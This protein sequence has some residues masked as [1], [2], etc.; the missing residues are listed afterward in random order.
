MRAVCDRHGA[1]LIL[2]EVMCGMGRS[3][4]LHAWEQEGVVP[5]IQMIAK[6]L[7]GGYQPIGG[8]LFGDKI[9]R[10]M[11]AG[12]GV[13]QHG[14]TYSAHPVACAAA[15]AVQQVIAEEGLLAN[16]VAR[17]AQLEA[18]LRARFADHPNVGEVRGRGLFWAIEFVADRE[19]KAPFPA[20]LAMNGRV[21]NAA[22]ARGLACYPVAGT[23]D[24][25]L[26]DHVILA[27]P[28]IATRTTSR[29]SWT[30]WPTGVDVAIRSV[31]RRAA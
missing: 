11:R 13:H 24:G 17:G 2:D 23:I 3:G 4:T 8:I 26:G 7:G 20:H 22:F 29:S 30:A 31:Q 18:L 12:S 14:H 5:D 10:A 1:L 25:K 28:Y 6:G 27:P 15:L 19:T 21:K 9:M 16:V